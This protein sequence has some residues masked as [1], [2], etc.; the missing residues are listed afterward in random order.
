VLSTHRDAVAK[1][2]LQGP[3]VLDHLS[4]ISAIDPARDAPPPHLP[5][6]PSNPSGRDGTPPGWTAEV[7]VRLPEEADKGIR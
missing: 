3:H 7:G 4:L 2:P 6:S 1:M 5:R